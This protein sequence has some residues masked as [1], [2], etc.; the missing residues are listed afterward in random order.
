[1]GKK[2]KDGKMLIVVSNDDN[3]NSIGDYIGRWNIET[4]FKSFK[5]SGFGI[6]DTHLRHTERISNLI[7]LVSISFVWSCLVG[8]SESKI[9]EIE[10]KK[11]GRKAKSIFR[12]GFDEISQLKLWRPKKDKKYFRIMSI[13]TCT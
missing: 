11:H 8:I 9:K 13:L 7:S 10:I 4:M 3:E 6:E 1:M 12:V 5:S 2:L